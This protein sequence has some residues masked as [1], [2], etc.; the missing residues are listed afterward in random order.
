MLRIEGTDGN[1]IDDTLNLP[2]VA[3]SSEAQ[4]RRIEAVGEAAVDMQALMESF[5]AKMGMLRKIIEAGGEG[6]SGHVKVD[7]LQEAAAEEA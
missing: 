1:S 2:V 4:Q 7:G 5:D 3:K 6:L